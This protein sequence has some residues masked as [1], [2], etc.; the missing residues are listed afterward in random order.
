MIAGLPAQDSLPG[1]CE[2]F[3]G[4]VETLQKRLCH[5]SDTPEKHSGSHPHLHLYAF[6]HRGGFPWPVSKVEYA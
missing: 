3:F 1:L 4:D 2:A 5:A 6:S